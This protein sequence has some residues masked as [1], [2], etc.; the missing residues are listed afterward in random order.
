MSG[1][2]AI[3]R[4]LHETTVHEEI[5]KTANAFDGVSHWNGLQFIILLHGRFGEYCL[6]ETDNFICINS[7]A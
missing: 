5:I 2:I 4:D 1:V 3:I 7:V 6:K